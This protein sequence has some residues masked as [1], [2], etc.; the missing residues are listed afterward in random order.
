MAI[1]PSRSIQ[2]LPILF[3]ERLGD[4]TDL[5]PDLMSF[6][7]AGLGEFLRYFA[8]FKWSVAT[9][10]PLQRLRVNF[11][12]LFE[13]HFHGA[14]L[15]TQVSYE[16]RHFRRSWREGANVVRARAEM[17]PIRLMDKVSACQTPFR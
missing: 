10:S 3:E 15:V 11:D 14:L 13:G 4:V 17:I 7:V 12:G 1:G 2:A 5:E 6:M 16:F 9:R 8:R